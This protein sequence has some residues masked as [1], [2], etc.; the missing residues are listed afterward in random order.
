MEQEGMVGGEFGLVVQSFCS[1]SELI[2]RKFHVFYSQ[3]FTENC[4]NY[5][6]VKIK[7]SRK[8]GTQK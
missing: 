6:A 2:E 3:V 4:S 7:S 1:G 5:T 8:A